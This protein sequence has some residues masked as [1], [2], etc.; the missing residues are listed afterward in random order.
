MW[1]RKNGADV[2]DSTRRQ[3]VL[4]SAPSANIGFVVVISLA[5]NDYIEIG[6]AGDSTSLRFDA[7]AATAFAPSTAAVKVGVTQIQL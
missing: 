5:A 1:V 3:G 7:A 6:Y 4:G 2:A